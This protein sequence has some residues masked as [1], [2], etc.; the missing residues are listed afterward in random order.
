M[1]WSVN[2]MIATLSSYLALQVGAL[3]F[4]STPS[5]VGPIRAGETVR[6]TIADVAPLEIHFA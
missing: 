2:E 4:T 5:G 1:I 6:C 3:I